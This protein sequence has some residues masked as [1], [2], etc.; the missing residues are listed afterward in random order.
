MPNVPINWQDAFPET[1]RMLSGDGVLLN[2]SRSDGAVNTMTIGW[3][4]FGVIWGRP[5]A[6][7]FV[8]PSRYTYGLME[9]TPDF[10]VNVLPDHMREDLA[11]C[12]SH[13][14]R[15]I[16]KFAARH[17][18][19]VSAQEVR[20]PA[21]EEATIVFECRTLHRNDV[22]PEALDPAVIESYYP[23]GDFH[24]CYFGEIV[25]CYGPRPSA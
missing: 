23:Q 9:E 2:S 4:T 22:V 13:S 16:D 17:L 15:E 6:I 7:V 18:T 5:M 8:R 11:F 19:L 24:R 3:A 21:I 20:T 14:G 10:T 1:V 25:A 12:G